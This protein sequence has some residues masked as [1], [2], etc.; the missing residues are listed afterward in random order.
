MQFSAQNVGALIVLSLA[1]SGNGQTPPDFTGHWR[2]QSDSGVQRRLDIEQNGKTLYVKTTVTN[3]K[4]TR[5]VQVKYKIGGPETVY[6]GFDGDEFHSSVHW[7]AG[8][9]LFDT[10]EHEDGREI[11]ET[12]VWTLS[13]DRNNLQVKRESAESGKTKDVLSTYVRQ[14]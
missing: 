3:S 9:L 7:I 6:R 4:G 1:L 12:T 5:Q 8:G 11:P 14:P 2:Q 13:E 10:V